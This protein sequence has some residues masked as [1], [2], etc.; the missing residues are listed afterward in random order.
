LAY[1][2]K[3]ETPSASK[4]K[5]F[6]LDTVTTDKWGYVNLISIWYTAGKE[7]ALIFYLLNGFVFTTNK[8]PN[9]KRIT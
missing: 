3:Y 6:F 9:P 1:P 5:G 7:N 4:L 8:I 2:T